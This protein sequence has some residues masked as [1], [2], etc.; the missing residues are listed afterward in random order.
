MPLILAIIGVAAL[1]LW[2]KGSRAASPAMPPAR[3]VPLPGVNDS[4]QAYD[5]VSTVAGA[6]AQ[7]ESGGRQFDANG[8]VIRSSAGALG[9]MQL[10]PGTAADLG[11]DPYD[12]ADNLRGGTLYL[13]QMYDRYGDW[14][15]ALAAYNWGPGNVDR[16]LASGNSYPSPVEGYVNNVSGTLGGLP[17]SSG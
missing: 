8:N 5:P 1:Y 11:V 9:I 7:V 4:V 15:D 17:D 12:A 2:F 3:G 14:R 6:V 16:A 10:M 13:G